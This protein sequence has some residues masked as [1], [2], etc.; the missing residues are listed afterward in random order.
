[1]IEP[2]TEF[3]EYRTEVALRFSKVFTVGDVRTRVYMDA[4]NIF[5]Q[6]RV[7]ARNRFYGGSG[8]KNPDFLRVI[9]IEPGRQLSF[10]VQT[11]F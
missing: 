2:G 5:N 4:N 9:G 1:M 6:A 11:S 7:T 3:E 8:V 10:G